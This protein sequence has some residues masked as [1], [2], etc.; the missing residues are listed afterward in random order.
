MTYIPYLWLHKQ[1]PNLYYSD[2]QESSYHPSHCAILV[3][4][5]IQE[6]EGIFPME[7]IRLM[8]PK[9]RVERIIYKSLSVPKCAIILSL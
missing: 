5:C 9:L 3:L 1:T 4:F 8:E 6:G 2:L 7:Y